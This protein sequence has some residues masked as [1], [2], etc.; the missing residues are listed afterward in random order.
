LVE[1]A[2]RL[3]GV[4]DEYNILKENEVFLKISPDN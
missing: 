3:I 1:N 4:I 2:A